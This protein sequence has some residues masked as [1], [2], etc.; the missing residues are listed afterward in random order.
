[1]NDAEAI[2]AFWYA[3]GRDTYRP[4]WFQKHDAFDGEIRDRFG[5]LIRPAR[6]GAFDTWAE[7]PGGAL[8]LLILLDQFP[9]EYLR[10]MCLQCIRKYTVYFL[11][12]VHL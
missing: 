5:A 10:L 12:Q 3:E 1:M 9:H 11:N 4:I 8:A 6:E 7:T 2:R